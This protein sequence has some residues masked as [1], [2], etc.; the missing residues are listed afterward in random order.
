MGGFIGLFLGFILGAVYS[1]LAGISHREG[2]S[3]YAALVFSMA[4]GPLL[5]C[6]SFLYV[7]LYW[8]RG[9]GWGIGRG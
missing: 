4:G 1:E 6:G 9:N 3:G 2:A 8:T 7:L 5:A